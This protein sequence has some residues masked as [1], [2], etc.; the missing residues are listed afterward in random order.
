MAWPVLPFDH[1]KESGESAPRPCRSI[2]NGAERGWY[3]V[4]SERS[5]KR[6]GS[7]K[8]KGKKWCIHAWIKIEF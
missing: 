2:K 4:I 6:K 7:D 8:I 5:K 3:K 1:L